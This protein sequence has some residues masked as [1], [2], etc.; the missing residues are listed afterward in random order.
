[1]SQPSL[2]NITVNLNLDIVVE[3]QLLLLPEFWYHFKS[4]ILEWFGFPG[5]IFEEKYD[6]IMQYNSTMWAEFLTKKQLTSEF[7]KNLPRNVW[8]WLEF[9]S[10]FEP[11]SWASANVSFKSKENILDNM[12]II[13]FYSFRF[14]TQRNLLSVVT[15]TVNITTSST[16]SNWMA[17]PQK[18]TR[19]YSMEIS[20]IGEVFLSN[21]F[22]SF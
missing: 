3:S 10:H 1:M 17:N 12:I 20:S 7:F 5:H 9:C 13:Y 14:P 4:R 6:N 2:V 18:R 21:A 22:S 11:N 15:S 8:F 19:T 16:Y